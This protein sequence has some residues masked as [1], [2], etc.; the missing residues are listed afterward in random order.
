MIGNQTASINSNRKMDNVTFVDD[1][2]S[3]VLTY[4]LAAILLILVVISFLGNIFLLMSLGTKQVRSH[5]DVFSISLAGCDIFFALICVFPPALNYVARRNVT[6]DG[7][8]KA[9]TYFFSMA[10][11]TCMWQVAF[12]CLNHFVLI[13]HQDYFTKY[14]SHCATAMQL[15]FCYAMP[16]LLLIPGLRYHEVLYSVERLRCVFESKSNFGVMV[17]DAVLLVI[18]PG[19]MTIVSLTIAFSFIKKQQNRVWSRENQCGPVDF[20]RRLSGLSMLRF[21]KDEVPFFYSFSAI[22]ARTLIGYVLLLTATATQNKWTSDVLIVLDG[23]ALMTLCLDPIIYLLTQ[24][25]FRTAFLDILSC[26][27]E[28]EDQLDQIPNSQALEEKLS[29]R[30]SRRFSEVIGNP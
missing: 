5:S 28:D 10:I 30:L 3:A 1:R 26:R 2:P 25:L 16:V 27:S 8:C 19:F 13:S 21:Q 14:K 24:E 15:F 11:G 17:L 6:G 22:F 7:I 20:N 23:I 4:T 9:Q 18:L 29:R 12:T